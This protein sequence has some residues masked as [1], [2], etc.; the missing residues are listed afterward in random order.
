M[1][2]RVASLA[3]DPEAGT[4]FYTTDNLGYRNLLAYD[5]K[6]GKSKTL[7]KGSASA[8]SHSI[9]PTARCGGCVPT[10]AS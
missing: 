10:M 5:L 6:T 3:L 8:T 7:L 9:A 1:Q 2:Y 4:L